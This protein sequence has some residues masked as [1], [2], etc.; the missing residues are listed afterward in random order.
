MFTLGPMP[1]AVCR[2]V[3]RLIAETGAAERPEGDKRLSGLFLAGG[4]GGCSYLDAEGEVWDWSPWDESIELVPDGV[5]KVGI[6]ALAARCIPELEAWLPARPSDAQNCEPCRGS[7]SIPPPLN[8]LQC[9]ECVCLG[10]V[11]HGRP[12]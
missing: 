2:A 11:L 3:Q 5:V 7:G 4:P 6:V 10:W 1:E 8:R 12:A 9:P